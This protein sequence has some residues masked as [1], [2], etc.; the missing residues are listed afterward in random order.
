MVLGFGP[1][2]PN[3]TEIRQIRPGLREDQTGQIISAWFKIAA[4]SRVQQTA[5]LYLY[6][7][8]TS[9]PMLASA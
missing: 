5:H 8:E 2:H 1:N 7:T 6:D 9:S 4:H 3:F